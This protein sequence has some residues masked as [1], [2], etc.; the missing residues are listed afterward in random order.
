MQRDDSWVV[1]DRHGRHLERLNAG[2]VRADPRG[3]IREIEEARRPPR[4]LP[5]EPSF[6]LLVNDFFIR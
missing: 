6:G 1:A 3:L 4:T 5:R 2:L